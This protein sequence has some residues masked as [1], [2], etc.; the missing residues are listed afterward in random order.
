MKRYLSIIFVLALLLLSVIP[1]FASEA[2]DYTIYDAGDT[3]DGTNADFAEILSG[4]VDI[5]NESVSIVS[6]TTDDFY[7]I[8]GN[9]LGIADAATATQKIEGSVVDMAEL[10]SDDE[11]A[12]LKRHIAGIR[13]KYEFD[14]VIVTTPSTYGKDIISYSDDLYDY[15]GYGAGGNRDGILFCVNLNEGA[16]EGNRDYYTSTRGFGITAFTDYA[17]EDSE[18]VINAAVLPYLA[19]GDWN[20]AFNKY[21]DLADRFLEEAKK[22]KPYDIFHRYKTTGAIIMGEVIA[23]GVAALIALLLVSKL[24]KSLNTAI[25]K[26]DAHDYARGGAV[27]TQSSDRFRTANVVRTKI[28]QNTRS[29]G[30]GGGGSSTHTSSSG[31][32][33]GGGGGKF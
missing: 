27:L 23:V 8:A 11:E 7:T 26:T 2:D 25:V 21:L 4:P 6:D 32:S 31:A 16:G 10:L 30:G 17:I 19:D 20:G 18:S 12:A 5:L 13:E 9:A 33:H 1:A 24:K 28:E 14:I 3:A 15:N 29:G 22:G